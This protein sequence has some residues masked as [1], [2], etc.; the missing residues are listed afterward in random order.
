METWRDD[1]RKAP[2]GIP[3]PFS[4]IRVTPFSV[5]QTFRACLLSTVL[6]TKMHPCNYGKTGRIG[7]FVEQ[8]CVNGTGRR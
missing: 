5:N 3:P 8:R 1:Q 4:L 2:R 6:T 7:F